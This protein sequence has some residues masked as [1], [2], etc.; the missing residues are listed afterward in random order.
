MKRLLIALMFTAIAA[1]AAKPV[2][3]EI[4]QPTFCYEMTYADVA[5]TEFLADVTGKKF[6]RIHF[7]YGKL[8]DISGYEI[9]LKR[10]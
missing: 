4:C 3:V 2:T 1:F 5:K 8:L 6:L 7:M 10:K 9:K